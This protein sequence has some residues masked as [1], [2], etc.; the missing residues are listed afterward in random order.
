MQRQQ[1]LE[2]RGL[3]LRCSELSMWAVAA[4]QAMVAAAA[5]RAIRAAVAA[6]MAVW[7]VEVPANT[8][9]CPVGP[10]STVV[11]ADADWITP[12]EPSWVAEVA[13]AKT[14]TTSRPAVEMVAAS[15]FCAPKP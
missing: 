6:A 1:A 14:T 7:A 15:S 3:V 13:R 9:T 11:S 8:N 10:K 5:I 12:T 4:P 2:T